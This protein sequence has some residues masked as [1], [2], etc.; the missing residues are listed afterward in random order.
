MAGVALMAGTSHAGGSSS[1]SS[2]LRS[3]CSAISGRLPGAVPASSYRCL[4]PYNSRS[5]SGALLLLVPCYLGGCFGTARLGRQLRRRLRM[6]CRSQ[7]LVVRAQRD[8]SKS[9]VELTEKLER[10]RLRQEMGADVCAGWLALQGDGSSASLAAFDEQYLAEVVRR[11]GVRGGEATKMAWSLKK[12]D[13]RA[14]YTYLAQHPEV[15]QEQLRQRDQWREGLPQVLMV[16][17]KPSVAKL[18]AEFLCPEGVRL[19]ERRGVASP[20]PI[21]E[22]PAVFPPTGQKS[23]ICVTSVIGHIFGLDFDKVSGSGD[24]LYSAPV[25]KSFTDSSRKFRIAEHLQDL[26]KDSQQLCLWLDADREGENI[27][28]EVIACCKEFFPDSQNVYRSIFSAL[29]REEVRAAFQ[30]LG[31]PNA[32]VAQGVDARQELDLRVGISFSRLLTQR[33]N[34]KGKGRPITYGPCQ[35]PALGF[36]VV[37]QEEIN[38]FRPQKIWSPVARV[39]PSKGGRNAT[40]EMRWA[41]G[42]TL[43][44]P[45][46][47]RLEAAL[48]AQLGST[49]PLNCSRSQEKIHR[50]VGLNTVHLLRTASNALG[51][52]PKQAMKV[53]EDLYSAGLI[54][55]PRTET[56]RYHKTFDAA[57]SLRPQ[58]KHPDWG[59]AARRASSLWKSLAG[60]AQSYR[61]RDVGDHP[62][63]VPMQF[64]DPR[65]LQSNERRL[66]ELICRHFIAS[67]LG[68]ASIEKLHAEFDVGGFVFEFSVLRLDGRNCQQG[69]LEAMPWRKGELGILDSTDAQQRKQ[70]EV[71]NQLFAEGKAA[72]LDFQLCESR[73]SPPKPLT[74]AELVELMDKNGIGTDASISTHIQNIQDRRYVQL[75]DGSG[76]P[77]ETAGSAAFGMRHGGRRP[78]KQ[79]SKPKAPGR[80][81]VPTPLGMGLVRGLGRLDASLCEPEVRAVIESECAKVGT[82]ELKHQ[83]VLDRNIQLFCNKYRHVEDHIADMKQHFEMAL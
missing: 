81:L 70:S 74:E 42:T 26:A 41:G 82:G 9:Y 18:V 43:D 64:S 80:F 31:R 27:C 68:D 61:A 69:W 75:C 57:A 50:P 49:L 46:V 14:Y 78:G 12:A 30:S 72:L 13:D 24:Y 77:I 37:R 62:P 56:T 53:A 5:G 67:W 65:A 11:C 23:V 2:L 19:R 66:Y 4:T 40:V 36:C 28:F 15:Y 25:V 38:G 76:A 29:T 20:C 17:E 32:Q 48:R 55:Y 47:E 45:E 54:S 59:Q 10:L 22:F 34:N 71:A 52:G 79:P 1:S 21:F 51:M 16:A 44:R 58:E 39:Q 7:V 3:S 8:D 33:L 83:E 6:P 73:T 35:T 63:I 60:E